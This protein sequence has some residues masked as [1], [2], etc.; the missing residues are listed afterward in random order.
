[1][2]MKQFTFLGWMTFGA[3]AA[4]CGFATVLQQAKNE[5]VVLED[6]ISSLERTVAQNEDEKNRLADRATRQIETASTELAQAQQAFEQVKKDQLLLAQAL[7]LTRPTGKSY[8]SWTEAFSLPLGISLRLPPGTKTYTDERGFVAL[9]TAQATSSLPW[10]SISPFS[11]EQAARLEGTIQGP[12]AVSYLVA[13]NLVTGV[14]GLR[15][16]QTNGYTYVLQVTSPLSNA[17]TYLIWAQTTQG[18]TEARIQDTLATL[19]FRT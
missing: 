15:D 10:L 3:F 16:G 11:L 7:P 5:R 13:G 8:A 18:I 4:A 14:R 2:R 17:A 12:E 6:R 9:P 19:T 1:M